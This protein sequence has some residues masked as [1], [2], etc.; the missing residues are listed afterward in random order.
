[1][2]ELSLIKSVNTSK[3]DQVRYELH[4]LTHHFVTSHRSYEKAKDKIK[5]NIISFY[6]AYLSEHGGHKH[7]KGF[8]NIH[9]ELDNIRGILNWCIDEQNWDTFIG[10]VKNTCYFWAI[11]GYWVDY[12]YYVGRCMEAVANFGDEKN[13]AYFEMLMSWLY[14]KRGRLDIAMVSIKNALQL[15]ELASCTEGVAWSIREMGAIAETEERFDDAVRGYENSLKLWENISREDQVSHLLKDLGE[16][17]RKMGKLEIAKDYMSRSLTI[18][19]KR[20]DP[21]AI[22]NRISKLGQIAFS[23]SDYPQAE[24]LIREG[25]EMHRK[26]QNQVMQA[27]DLWFLG[28]IDEKRGKPDAALGLYDEAHDIFIRLDIRDE[29][30]VLESILTSKHRLSRNMEVEVRLEV[31]QDLASQVLNLSGLGPY[32]LGLPSY[33][34]MLDSYCDTRDQNLRRNGYSCRLRETLIQGFQRS[35]QVTLKNLSEPRDGIHERLELEIAL[36]VASLSYESWPESEVKEL[37]KFLSAGAP[38]VLLFG[39]RQQRYQREVVSDKCPV[40]MISLDQVDFRFASGKDQYMVMEIELLAE[41]T[42]SDLES[43]YGLIK[44]R[45]QCK[46]MRQ[47]KFQRALACLVAEQ[48]R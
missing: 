24:M 9:N 19:R 46:D 12:E 41:G 47:S 44:A 7:W 36:K 45:W 13:K 31:S 37:V 2:T 16:L 14:R 11:R 23:L 27:L 30:R 33:K 39:L 28:Q 6:V 38:L 48:T 4:P 18:E 22:A 35:T 8:Q 10:L 15:F 5:R 25:L 32:K 1:L 26:L 43:L 42:L 29:P 3:V 34:I 20:G 17:H 40:A 21:L